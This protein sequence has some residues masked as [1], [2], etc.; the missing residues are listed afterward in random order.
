MTRRKSVLFPLVILGCACGVVATIVSVYAAEE[1]EHFRERFFAFVALC[2][3][4]IPII[5]S[6]RRHVSSAHLRLD[7]PS[8]ILL[9]AIG[10]VSVLS[11]L[12]QIEIR[13]TDA[14]EASPFNLA[15][16]LRTGLIA[17]A[18]LIAFVSLVGSGQL[19][20]TLTGPL[21]PFVGFASAAIVSSSY[22]VSRLASLAHSLPYAAMVICSAAM[23]AHGKAERR[24]SSSAER[25]WF[26]IVIYMASLISATWVGVIIA[27]DVALR[28]GGSLPIPGAG[29]PYVHH[30][31]LG[32][33]SGVLLVWF[34]CRLLGPSSAS[35][36]PSV[37]AMLAL[38]TLVFSQ[39][40]SALAASVVAVGLVL[41]LT[42]RGWLLLVLLG[43]LG[44][45]LALVWPDE[46]LAY[47]LR[48]QSPELF[49]TLTGRTRL[50][51]L[52]VELGNQS[53]II[54]HGYY[55]GV[56]LELSEIAQQ[57][58]VYSNVSTT[59]NGLLRAYVELGLIGLALLCVAIAGVFVACLRLLACGEPASRLVGIEGAGVLVLVIARTMSGPGVEILSLVLITMLVMYVRLI[60]A[61]DRRTAEESGAKLAKDASVAAS[62][63]RSQSLSAGWRGGYGIRGRGSPP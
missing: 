45:V 22:A 38:V 47:V 55:T 26:I 14:I 35:G 34:T 29:I 46:L 49:Q 16:L 10:A 58:G 56:R 60:L 52:A 33:M 18:G 62:T 30:T 36:L 40:R 57:V 4:C 27:P 7:S 13:T 63:T 51:D 3:V 23:L 9:L 50:W 53:P 48:G 25:L 59:D 12:P 44:L 61:R 39:S 11:F 8:V 37:I 1:Y 32:F 2:I 6:V 28:A 20:A 24:E 5:T 19:A 43:W 15:N 54:G 31:L 42:Q 17:T 21:L 41:L